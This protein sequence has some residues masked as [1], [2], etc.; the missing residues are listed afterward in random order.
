MQA[1]EALA[2]EQEVQMALLVRRLVAL[3]LAVL[4]AL[5][6]LPVILVALV[7]G[8]LGH[9]GRLLVQGL[10]LALQGLQA[11]AKVAPVLQEDQEQE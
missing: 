5:A 9:L 8:L 1:A 4:L 2:Q 10:E 11:L 3:P 7:L 6:A